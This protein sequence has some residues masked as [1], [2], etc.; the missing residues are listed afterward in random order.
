MKKLFFILFSIVSTI[1]SG[2]D[3]VL[4]AGAEITVIGNQYGGSLTFET[5]KYWAAG[6]FYQT[7]ITL[8]NG[9][10]KLKYPFYGIALQAP[11]VRTEKISFV[12]VIRTGLVNEKFLAVVPSL[13]TRIHVTPKAGISVGAGLRSGYPSFSAKLFIRLF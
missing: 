11:I 13:E 6:A 10:G 1:A 9:E 2:Q 4:S 12:A 7:G 3:I 8:D 5:K